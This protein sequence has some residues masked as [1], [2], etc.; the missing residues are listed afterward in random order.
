MRRFALSTVALAGLLVTAPVTFADPQTPMA[1]DQAY[2]A[3]K[4]TEQSVMPPPAA[5]ASPADTA[6]PSRSGLGKDVPVGFGWG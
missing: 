2:A 3:T 4:A 1:P 5:A 6:A